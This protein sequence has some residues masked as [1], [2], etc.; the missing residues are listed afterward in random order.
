MSG[1]VFLMNRSPSIYIV[2]A[3]NLIRCPSFHE[4]K[5]DEFYT[6]DICLSL[7]SVGTLEEVNGGREY[8]HACWPSRIVVSRE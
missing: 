6:C 7:K 3:I 8:I 5:M 4:H 2:Q 1:Y